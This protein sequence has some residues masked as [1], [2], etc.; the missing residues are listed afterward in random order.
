MGYREGRRALNINIPDKLYAILNRICTDYGLSKT[1]CISQYLR[2]L[3]AQHYAKRRPL[4][5]SSK[6]SFK[7]E[8]GY[9]SE[10]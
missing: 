3:E 9:D 4:S 1:E 8:E 5:A 6:K 7:L 2:Y 10:L